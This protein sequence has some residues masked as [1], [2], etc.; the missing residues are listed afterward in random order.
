MFD[1]GKFRRAKVQECGRF[2]AAA[3]SVDDKL[4][5]SRLAEQW[6]LRLFK[7]NEATTLLRFHF[8]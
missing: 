4:F 6:S 1:A 3:L 7:G 5:W 2:A 8:G